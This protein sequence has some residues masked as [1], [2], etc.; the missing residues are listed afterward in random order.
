MNKLKTFSERPFYDDYDADKGYLQILFRPGLAVQA[1]E[2]TQMQTIL[3]NQIAS[4]GSHFFDNGARILGGETKYYRKIQFLKISNPE[5][6]PVNYKVDDGYVQLGTLKAKIIHKITDGANLVLYVDYVSGDGIGTL[7]EIPINSTIDLLT[8]N[9][10]SQASVTLNG[11]NVSEVGYGALYSVNK[12]V[13]YLNSRFVLVERQ[14][15]V[16]SKYIDINE[17]ENEI[18]VGF[19]VSDL[20]ITPEDDE[21]LYDN[22]IGSPN[23]SAPGAARYYMEAI[24]TVKADD[25]K[26]FVEIVKIKTGTPIIKPVISDYSKQFQE[27]FARRT[28]DESGDYVINDFILDVRE[29]YNNG[30]NR[31]FTDLITDSNPTPT[32]AQINDAKTKISLTLDAGKAYVR[33]FEIEKLDNTNLTVEK[34][35]TTEYLED[36]FFNTEYEK[37]V[38]CNY[39]IG[40]GGFGSNAFLSSAYDSISSVS[41]LE[42]RNSSNAVIFSAKLKYITNLGGGKFHIIFRDLIS[43]S[44]SSNLVNVTNVYINNGGA[45]FNNVK[46]YKD[47]NKSK[48]LYKLPYSVVSNVSD[49]IYFAYE[50]SNNLAI[51]N[52]VVTFTIFN[53]SSNVNDYTISNTSQNKIVEI[54]T[55]D[56]QGSSVRFNLAPSSCVGG[57][58]MVVVYKRGIS[59]GTNINKTLTTVTNETV[60]QSGK[61][62][63]CD[64]HSIIS[65][66]TN[67]TNPVDV[68]DKF[69][70]D[71]G[72]RDDRYDYGY[73]RLKEGEIYP[74]LGVKV[75]YNYFTWSTGQYISVNSYL[76]NTFTVQDVPFYNNDS[77]CNYI[78]FR[79]KVSNPVY[80]EV[81]YK[82]TAIS[83]YDV[84]LPR[85]DKIILNKNGNFQI[86]SGNPSLTPIMP[87]DAEDSIT[88]YELNIPAY[89]FKL[90]DVV[91]KKLNYKRYTMKDLSQLEK[92]IENLEYYTSLSLLEADIQNKNY[93]DKFKSGFL[94]D[95]FDTFTPSQNDSELFKVAID[96]DANNMRPQSV[97]SA[98]DLG[99]FT[100]N[101]VVVHS[102]NIVTLSYNSVKM[103]EQKYA[104]AIERIQPF[105]RYVWAGNITLNPPF[106]NWVTSSYV[107]TTLDAGSGVGNGN[108]A[109]DVINQI[110]N[111]PTRI[112]TGVPIG[113][114]TNSN[115][116]SSDTI[117][118]RWNETGIGRA[119]FDRKTITTQTQYAGSRAI[120]VSAIPFIRS[121]IVEFI[122]KGLKPNTKV[123]LYFDGKDMSNYVSTTVNGI[124]VNFDNGGQDSTI[125]TAH[126]LI[127]DGNGDLNGYM[128][129]PNN[130]KIRFKTGNK[131]IVISDKI[132][133]PSTITEGVYTANGT[134]TTVQN[135][136]VTTRQV[137]HETV[138]YD[139]VAQSFTMD[140]IEGGFV[141]GVKIFFS[142]TI[143]SNNDNVRIEIRSMNNGYP[144]SKAIA[145]KILTPSELNN[146]SSSGS[147]TNGTKGTLFTFD[148]PIYLEGNT[149]HCFVVITNSETL[150][151]WTSILG[152]KD[153][154]TGEYVN[155]QPYLGSMFKSQNNTTWTAEQLQDIKF[156]IYKASFNNSGSIINKE[157]VKPTD[158][159]TEADPFK[160]FLEKNAFT[161]NTANIPVI[162]G[163]NG[164]VNG[165][166]II[167]LKYA[168]GVE[169]TA[170][171]TVSSGVISGITP[172][173]PSSMP[174]GKL[175]V[176]ACYTNLDALIDP[177]AINKKLA[178]VDFASF[179]RVKVKHKLHG[180]K[181]ADIVK[182]YNVT[183]TVPITS[184]T[185]ATFIAHV[186]RND[187]HIVEV[188]DSDSY[189]IPNPLDYEVSSSEPSRYFTFGAVNGQIAPLAKRKMVYS[190]VKLLADSIVFNGTTLD[191]DLY[192]TNLSD[193]NIGTT[194]TRIVEDV[195]IDL[196]KV[197]Y[198]D[199]NDNNTKVKLVA[200]LKTNS[201][202]LS[203]VVDIE[204][205]TL[206]TYYNK[207]NDKNDRLSRSNIANSL[208]NEI[209]IYNSE[210]R[211]ITKNIR[212]ANPANLIELYADINLPTNCNV[213][214]SCA[215]S[216]EE[217][218]LNGSEVWNDMVIEN[219]KLTY[220][221]FNESVE[222][223]FTFN[224]NSEFTNYRIRILPINS[225]TTLDNR[226]EVPIVEKLR[227]IALYS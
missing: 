124:Q 32:I 93:I 170:N 73:I 42:F 138:W 176:D 134:H 84:Y 179:N 88:L 52:D 33:G 191:Y 132:D 163:G 133:N 185:S 128:F 2:L 120:D 148:S 121:R 204:R 3:Q 102:D 71:N 207:I 90:E 28:Y 68:T 135:V 171:V 143:T 62:S 22:A 107:D 83:T 43:T 197:K 165:T 181:T 209:Q 8:V 198:V 95:N 187:G 127:T 140:S 49:L 87:K 123:N 110:Y 78:D 129:I 199:Y 186:N 30:S 166:S 220:T 117:L 219:G 99:H 150:S 55:V 183:D 12:G 94:V 15:I 113:T 35:R 152:Q 45:I 21:S 177:L 147:Y 6:I 76:N 139:P 201:S 180:F 226:T 58:S 200:N 98:L 174:K 103:A 116:T 9:T 74:S 37:Y 172:N 48:L 80:T 215:V 60:S 1:R 105:A 17:N 164:Y 203:P 5:I 146:N 162:N 182:Y 159:N 26:D 217:I 151:L 221:G 79:Q 64:C 51:Q 67:D 109:S 111:S 112:F 218:L 211:Y 214:V 202:N 38:E 77:L 169:I 63:Q 223:K 126:N 31:G 216:N 13:Y 34:A 54:S 23:E 194:S 85:K 53:G 137:T 96:F 44:N 10:D 57:D 61:L 156:E 39:V 36:I 41:N 193:T 16:V 213:I 175:D 154:A 168:N 131:K 212:L 206:Y 190:K 72:Q 119:K 141:T 157:Y 14:T 75:T 20:I 145:T 142:E 24:L 81:A 46:I 192:T 108:T 144:T 59:D 225:V 104:T 161:Y 224:S 208:T 91:V 65:I 158:V 92:R 106:D 118:Q 101:G 130:D 56:V 18:S 173:M 155:K 115:T 188:I 97:A 82:E 100:W 19:N 210:S 66:M 27:I 4:I 189:Y 227:V 7:S 89:T 205:L 114:V 153:A 222:N 11:L 29:Y 40:S 69:I 125:T 86:L 122:S 167:N 196:D 195:L 149:E 70:L 178:F 50:K 160:T 184:T 47:D 25:V 136:F